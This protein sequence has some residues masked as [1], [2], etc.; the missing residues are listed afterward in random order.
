MDMKRMTAIKTFFERADR[1]SPEGGRK[2]TMDELKALNSDER[3]ELAIL[4]ARE[5][6]ETIDE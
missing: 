6:G 3:A 1:I 2:I 4:A 5:L